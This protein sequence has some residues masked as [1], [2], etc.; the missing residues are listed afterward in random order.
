[1]R[2]RDLTIVTVGAPQQFNLRPGFPLGAYPDELRQPQRRPRHLGRRR[3]CW[4]APLLSAW[5][6]RPAR[7][8]V[9]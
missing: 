7:R 4:R 8:P 1:M 3:S 5:R 9:V 2:T 6:R